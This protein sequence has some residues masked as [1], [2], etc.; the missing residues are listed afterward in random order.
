MNESVLSYLAE[1][2]RM[3][4]QQY[5]WQIAHGQRKTLAPHTLSKLIAALREYPAEQLKQWVMAYCEQIFA[6]KAGIPNLTVPLPLF[7][8]IIVPELKKGFDNGEA[9]S[10]L[11][12]AVNFSHIREATKIEPAI[13]QHLNLDKLD[14]DDLYD[15]ALNRD[16]DDKLIR[17]ALIHYYLY[18]FDNCLHEIPQGVL[19]TD[20]FCNHIQKLEVLLAAEGLLESYRDKL[21]LWRFHCQSYTDYIANRNDYLNYS[22]YLDKKGKDFEWRPWKYGRSFIV[23]SSGM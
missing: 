17:Q 5:E 10:T 1:N 14:F 4:W 6:P 21:A 18:S 13:R 16:P 9:R 22:D 12:I 23:R 8:E 20:W 7:A 3:L 15:M 19:A 2:E 11:W